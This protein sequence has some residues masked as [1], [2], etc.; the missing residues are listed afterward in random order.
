MPSPPVVGLR[1]GAKVLCT[2]KLDKDVRVGCMGVL[3]AFRDAAEDMQDMLLSPYDLGYGMDTKMA[4]ED[5]GCIHP[6]RLWP[7]LEFTVNGK[8]IVWTVFPALMWEG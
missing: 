4:K 1:V 5:W 2:V 7:Q 6:D 3:A 8:Q